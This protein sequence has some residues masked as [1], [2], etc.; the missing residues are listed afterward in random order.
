MS[1]LAER[2]QKQRWSL[3]PRGKLWLEDKNAFGQKMLEKMGW[4]HGKGLGANEDGRT[5][6]LHV[7]Y[8]NDNKGMGY[9]EIEGWTSHED[10]FSSLLKTLNQN[11]IEESQNTKITSLEKKVQNSRAR[12][13]YHKFTKAKDLSQYSEKDLANIF[14]KKSLKQTP[15]VE[16]KPFE[17]VETDNHNPLL[18]NKGSMLDYFKK[19][20]PNF[21]KSSLEKDESDCENARIGFGFAQDHNENH[22]KKKRSYTDTLSSNEG[23]FDEPSKKK[24]VKT[25]NAN[26]TFVSYLYQDDYQVNQV[27]E[28]EEK[29]PLE[30]EGRKK[31]KSK[32][33]NKEDTNNVEENQ[34]SATEEYKEKKSK[35]NIED[36]HDDKQTNDISIDV[37][38]KSKKKKQKNLNLTEKNETGTENQI[39]SNES[40]QNDEEQPS[41]DKKQKKSKKKHKES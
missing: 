16:E 18:M 17:N 28:N 33:K 1:M 13:N 5:E 20:L 14:G 21:G 9:K 34:N 12:I 3:N 25:S 31:K 10:D 40:I 15:N 7:T 35:S 2:R 30:R 38:S 32:Q 6:S 8:K 37:N 41:I 23:S 36:F 4:K 26:E 39:I 27:D 11:N 22:K 24:K 19:K 29:S